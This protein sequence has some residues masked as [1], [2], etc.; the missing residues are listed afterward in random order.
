MRSWSTDLESLEH[1]M[2][3][4]VIMFKRGLC[5]DLRFAVLRILTVASQIKA[6]ILK[7]ASA[8]KRPIRNKQEDVC[9]PG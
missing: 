9:L 7:G 2:Q 4:S 1:T 5:S 3:A 6:C 8:F